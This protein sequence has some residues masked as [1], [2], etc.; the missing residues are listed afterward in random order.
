M[1]DKKVGELYFG[2]LEKQNARFCFKIYTPRKTLLFLVESAEKRDHIVEVICDHLKTVFNEEL[3]NAKVKAAQELD[4]LVR[5]QF[6]VDLEKQELVLQALAQSGIVA[7]ISIL[8]SP[9]KDK[10]GVLKMYQHNELFDKDDE[11]HGMQDQW[12]EYYFVLFSD[13]LYYFKHSKV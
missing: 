6:V 5:E 8:S 12:V 1:H 3:W 4:P 7:D 11:R 10:S 13:V 2:Y 9:D